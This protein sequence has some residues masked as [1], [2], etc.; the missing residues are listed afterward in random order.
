[1]ALAARAG[2]LLFRPM[3]NGW[4]AISG[5]ASYAGLG[6]FDIRV[7]PLGEASENLQ[8]P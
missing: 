1:M 5:L 3:E 7:S 8:D 6:T 4:V 2:Q